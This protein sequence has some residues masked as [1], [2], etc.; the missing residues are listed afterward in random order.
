MGYNFVAED[1]DQLFLIPPSITDW[2][3]EEHLAYFV[4]DAV[5]EMDLSTFYFDYRVDG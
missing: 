4:L 3:P 2:L 1:H 5:Q